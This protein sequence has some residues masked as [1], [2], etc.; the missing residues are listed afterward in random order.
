[1]QATI[2]NNG[3]CTSIHDSS[4]NSMPSSLR[5]KT[6]VSPTFVLQIR[7]T[8]RGVA[9]RK[10]GTLSEIVNNH[11]RAIVAVCCFLVAYRVG[12]YE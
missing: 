9:K 7:I 12:I 5:E 1:M 8:D 4:A 2:W 3:T 10:T 6:T 11:V